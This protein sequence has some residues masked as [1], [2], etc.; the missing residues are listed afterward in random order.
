MVALHCSWNIALHKKNA[1][2]GYPTAGTV[3]TS[4]FIKNT[5]NP[6]PGLDIK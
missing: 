6:Y 3:Q 1:H 4:D 5:W 2:M